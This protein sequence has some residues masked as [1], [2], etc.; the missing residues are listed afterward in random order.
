MT[1]RAETHVREIYRRTRRYRQRYERRICAC[2]LMCL[3]FLLTGI[4]GLLRKIRSPG[5]SSVT[6]GYGAVLLQN[7]AS[8]YI[9]V[10]IAAFIAGVTLTVLCIRYAKGRQHSMQVREEREERI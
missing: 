1:G 9:V 7:E 5:L 10:G 4:T 3:M 8:A 2:L 6:A